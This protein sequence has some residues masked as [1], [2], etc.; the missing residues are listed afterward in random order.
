[1]HHYAPLVAIFLPILSSFFIPIIGRFHSKLGAYFA[2]IILLITMGTSVMLLPIVLDCECLH[3]IYPWAEGINLQFEIYADALSVCVLL[4]TSFLCLLAAVYSIHYMA[5][6]EGGARYYSLFLLLS[7]SMMGV[8][9]SGNL[10]QFFMFLELTT[11]SCFLL[12]LHY[13]TTAALKSAYKYFIMIHLGALCLLTAIGTIYVNVG[14]LSMASLG[15]LL[16]NVN[17]EWL[18]AAMALTFVGFGIESAVVPLHVWLPDAHSNAPCPVSAIL[19]GLMVKIGIYGLI[20]FFYGIYGFPYA[21]GSTI[22]ILGA[23]TAFIGVICALVQTDAKRLIA[24]HTVSQLGYM[25]MAF[26]TGTTLGL[27]AC[28]THLANHTFFKALLFFV[29]GAVIYKTGTKDMDRLGGLRKYMPVTFICGLVASMAIAGIPPL[30]GFFSKGMTTQAVFEVSPV[31]SSIAII[32]GVMTLLSFTKLLYMIFWREKSLETDKRMSMKRRI[33]ASMKV[34]MIALAT[35]CVGFGL[36]AHQYLEK[37]ISPIINGLNLEGELY[38]PSIFM[39]SPLTS[40]SYVGIV[41]AGVV[42]LKRQRIIAIMSHKPFSALH[43]CFKE[44][45]G[46]DAAYSRLAKSVVSVFERGRSIMSGHLRDYVAYL[47]ALLFVLFLYIAL[48]R[49]F[50]WTF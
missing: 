31:M 13:Q 32:V 16:S 42:W 26:G 40:L 47:A 30:N 46:I 33:P 48:L 11:I 45:L 2:T 7:G 9:L 6:K 17:G 44:E 8:F 34:P 19:S 14:E 41:F 15:K 21:W 25:I 1:V 38:L 39:P 49:G 43:H 29:V 37:I 12:I 27:A 50:Q 5:Q 36:F 23:L 18:T 22:I 3:L 4:L 10:L 20:R 35:C 28:L 24:Y